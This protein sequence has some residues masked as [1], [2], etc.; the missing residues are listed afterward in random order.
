MPWRT[1][2]DA[3]SVNG[4]TGDVV[5]TLPFSQLPLF[6]K[7]TS[8]GIYLHMGIMFGLPLQ[9]LLFVCALGIAGLVVFG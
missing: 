2:S 5:D 9:I 6:S 3:V 4:E 7:L 1:N 8:W